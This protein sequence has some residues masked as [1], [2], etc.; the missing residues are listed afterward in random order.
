MGYKDF[1]FFED[2]NFATK[3][4]FVRGGEVIKRI[5]YDRQNHHPFS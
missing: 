5:C 3:K 1:L 2:G 4:Y